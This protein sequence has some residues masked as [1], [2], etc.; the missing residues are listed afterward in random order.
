MPCCIMGDVGDFES[1][2]AANHFSL[3]FLNLVFSCFLTLCFK[4]FSV[5]VMVTAFPVATWRFCCHGN[6]LHYLADCT[7][8]PG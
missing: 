1:L 4:N 2:K 8:S 6:D 7:T 3:V 5:I